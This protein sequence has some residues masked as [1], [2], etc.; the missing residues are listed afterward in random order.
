[1]VHEY[2]RVDR[3]RCLKLP[4]TILRHSHWP[5]SDIWV[6]NHGPGPRILEHHCIRVRARINDGSA[7]FN[8]LTKLF[9][10]RSAAAAVTIMIGM[11][12]RR[13]GSF[14]LLLRVLGITPIICGLCD[15]C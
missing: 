3:C 4:P 12:S 6:A 13:R 7:T 8:D 5:S 10:K 11:I 2:N 1:M 15:E 14:S 9:E